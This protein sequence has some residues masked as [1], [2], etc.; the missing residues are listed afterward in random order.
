[1]P[2]FQSFGVLPYGAQNFGA[3]NLEAEPFT[4][5]P[6]TQNFFNPPQPSNETPP[7][8][9]GNHPPPSS[10][11]PLQQQ[12]REEREPIVPPSAAS[13][14]IPE[15][16]AAY[17]ARAAL[18]YRARRQPQPLLIVLDLNGTLLFRPRRKQPQRFVARPH[19]LDFLRYCLRTFHVVI[20]SSARPD[21]VVA[22]VASPDLLSPA[23][24]AS[25]V[26]VW[27][28]DRF[29]L[30]RAD[31]A[32]RVQ[33]YKR[34]S[35][36]WADDT[37]AASHPG[38]DAAAAAGGAAAPVRWDQS[39]TVLVDDSVEKGRSEPHNLI[40]IPE[41]AGQDEKDDVLPQVHDY[42][43]HLACQEDVSAYIR[44]NPFRLQAGGW[45]PQA[46]ALS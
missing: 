29:A 15:P 45:K 40:Q 34:L 16:T 39:N 37:V 23:E 11:S 22:M 6:A 43:N 9:G 12:Q 35:L 27:A 32:R 18:P 17:L 7:L 41:F 42:I 30:S 33:C 24:R 31:Y 44:A 25:L 8:D 20:W 5:F 13:G 38:H 19:A 36:L 2:M 28:R 14:G 3:Q 1:M 4:A 26:A 46:E 10:S 21:N